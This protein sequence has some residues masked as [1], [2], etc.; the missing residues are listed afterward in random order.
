MPNDYQ[1]NDYQIIDT[2]AH[3][4]EPL[5]MWKEY[6]EPAYKSFAPSS[7]M[8]IQGEPI[9]YKVSNEVVT[10]WTQQIMK[11]HP[12][13]RLN[14]FTNELHLM[15]MKEMEIDISFIY[16][17]LG[18]AIQSIDAMKPQ[19]AGAF[20]RAYNNWLQDFCSYNPQKLQGI[21]IVNRHAPEAMVAE[22][23]QIAKLGWKAVCLRPN[24]VKG[25]LLSDPAYEPFWQEC[26]DLGI[27]VGI[28]EGTHSHLPSTGGDRFNTRFALRTCSHPMEQMMAMLA[29]IEGGVL[30]RHPKLRIG[31]LESGCGWLLYWLW[32]L[33]EEYECHYWEVKDNVK[34]KP[35]EYFR[36]QC[37]VTFEPS[38]PY[39]E[40]IIEYIGS[41][42]LLFG[43]DYPH[44]HWR[45][46]EDEPEF[47]DI[48]GVLQERLPSA[49]VQKILWDN[50]ARFYGL[51]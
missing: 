47:L 22:L 7:D 51:D 43:S 14:G 23:H 3:V 30:E 2:D 16:P 15:S 26:E 38:E 6:L 9:Y 45:I 31:F 48:N 27:A 46:N 37:F 21:G 17:T 20:A 29:L 11:A 41:D 32:R 10:H 8:K 34:M 1:I 50:P 44:I 40:R 49:T 19:V 42:N 5:S 13:A 18:M 36:R 12:M 28:H 39:I 25:R 24:P 35:S 33:D 4:F